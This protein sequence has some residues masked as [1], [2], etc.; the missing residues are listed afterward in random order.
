MEKQLQVKVI[1]NKN[2]KG[3]DSAIIFNIEEAEPSVKVIGE[4]GKAF[5]RNYY[6]ERLADHFGEE[7]YQYKFSGRTALMETM[8]KWDLGATL[9]SIESD[10]AWMKEAKKLVGEF[11]S[12]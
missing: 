4:D 7:Y 2:A 12:R 3:N 9:E 11:L 5:Y 10:P 1:G 6:P 8:K